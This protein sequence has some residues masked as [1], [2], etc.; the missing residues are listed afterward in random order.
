M[1]ITIVAIVV[2][3]WLFA[4]FVGLLLI[5]GL[6]ELINM[7]YLKHIYPSRQSVYLGS[8][9]Y[10][11]IAAL[12]R[13]D[14]MLMVSVFTTLYCFA[15]ILKRGKEARICDVGAT[16]MCIIYGGALPSHFLFIRNLDAGKLEY[17]GFS[18]D[19]AIGY[20][21]LMF[22]AISL[23]DIAAY[24][25]GTRFGKHKLWEVISPKKTIEGAVGGA[26]FAIL[27]AV[28]VGYIVHLELWQSLLAG[29]VIT[30]AAQFGDLF[31]SMLKRDAGTKDSS[32]ILP[33]HGGFLDRS[34]SYVFTVAVTYYFFYYVIVNPF[35]ANF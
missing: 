3:D 30:L 2:G 5:L 35:W 29:F 8:M 1:A 9:L 17:F 12:N 27:S 32:N 23:T 34:D 16:L 11:F 20:V 19:T 7:L 33:G 13:I 24:F 15:A 4:L 18:F 14:L 28:I 26:I 25:I 21:L 10:L 6:K 31:E 22:T